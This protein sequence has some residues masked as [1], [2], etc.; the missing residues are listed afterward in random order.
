MSIR[1][2]AVPAVFLAIITTLGLV[3]VALADAPDPK[4]QQ[5][6]V[7]TSEP[8]TVNGVQV[9]RVSVSGG[10]QWPTHKSDCNTNRTG[11]GYAIDWNDP[12][13]GGNH[14]TTLDGI[15]SIDVGSTG[16]AYNP[17]DNE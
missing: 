9:V 1:K 3:G 8:Y 13:A 5:A 14:V 16:N 4:P 6:Q 2:R 12:N 11:V 7:R 10:W 15:G 17:A